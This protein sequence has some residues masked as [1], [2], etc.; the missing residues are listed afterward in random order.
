MGPRF[1]NLWQPVAAC[2]GGLDALE[3]PLLSWRPADRRPG[4]WRT[5]R[6]GGLGVE[7]LQTGGLGF[8]GLQPLRPGVRFHVC[9]EGK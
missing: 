2:G 3:K 6:P 4:G 9:N 8:G 7:D 1:D 5:A